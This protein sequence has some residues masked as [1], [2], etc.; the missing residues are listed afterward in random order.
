MRHFAWL[1]L[2]LISSFVGFSFLVQAGQVEVQATKGSWADFQKDA[3]AVRKGL[4]DMAG[5]YLIVPIP[6]QLSD[7]TAD[8]LTALQNEKCLRSEAEGW[9]F[10]PSR[11]CIPLLPE[12]KKETIYEL[13][14]REFDYFFPSYEAKVEKSQEKV[15]K[16]QGYTQSHHPDLVI[17]SDAYVTDLLSKSTSKLIWT[18]SKYTYHSGTGGDGINCFGTAYAAVQL[19][20]EPRYR[21][22]N[23]FNWYVGMEKSFRVISDEN[24]WEFGDL[25]VFDILDDGHAMVY[26][27][28]DQATHK[29]VVFTKNGLLA[30]PFQTMLYDDVYKVY[31][32]YDITSV[33][34]YRLLAS[35][36]PETPPPLQTR[37]ITV[38]RSLAEEAFAR[39]LRSVVSRRLPKL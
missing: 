21:D 34:R 29:K 10:Y 16:S 15:L 35:K 25:I 19:R 20:T 1:K 28:T 23:E 33:R 14:L 27:G 31:N 36:K 39:H 9:M 38:K 24:D 5:A 32:E 7:Y 6:V 37:R 22:I 4:T 30:S 3:Q 2:A 13:I 11:K 8:E 17:S 12:A 18:M 26:V